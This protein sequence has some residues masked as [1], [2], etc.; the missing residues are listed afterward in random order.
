[1]FGIGRITRLKNGAIGDWKIQ[2]LQ[3]SRVSPSAIGNILTIGTNFLRKKNMTEKKSNRGG[4]REGA[5]RPAKENRTV[6]I[7]FCCY[8]EERDRLKEAVKESGKTQSAYILDKLF[9]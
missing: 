7:A 4:K 2:K 5:G 3:L 8:P 1:M 9:K 6:T